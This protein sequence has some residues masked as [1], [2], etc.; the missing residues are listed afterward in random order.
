MK[1]ALPVLLALVL[2]ATLATCT[3][4]VNL[5]PDGDGGAPDLD[6]GFRGLDGG[7]RGLDGGFI[8][9]PSDAQLDAAQL[10]AG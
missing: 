1:R 6:G 8:E 7:L 5:T 10:G 2:A 4:V 3:R 9:L